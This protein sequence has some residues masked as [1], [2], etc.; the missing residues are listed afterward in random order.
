MKKKLMM[1]IALLMASGLP[2]ALMSTPTPTPTP[3]ST[4]VLSPTP[5]ASIPGQ[6]GRV[7]VKPGEVYLSD[8]VSKPVLT[9]ITTPNGN[10]YLLSVNGHTAV[11][12]HHNGDT[13]VFSVHVPGDYKRFSNLWAYV[14]TTAPAAVTLN[15]KVDAQVSRMGVPASVTYFAGVDTNVAAVTYPGSL[16]DSSTR[17]VRLRLPVSG[18]AAALSSGLYRGDALKP[19]DNVTFTLSRQSDGVNLRFTRFEFEYERNPGLNP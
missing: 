13:G 6:L 19:G 15:L 11:S 2:R 10:P 3:T 17:E 9:P 16:N 5:V 18:T 12:L 4:P 14:S 1:G 7:R 8:R